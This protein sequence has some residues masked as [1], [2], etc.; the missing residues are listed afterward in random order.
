MA[1][2]VRQ[3]C[4]SLLAGHV[5]VGLMVSTVQNW[6]PCSFPA[7]WGSLC[8]SLIYQLALL[9]KYQDL[10]AGRLKRLNSPCIKLVLCVYLSMLVAS[11][12]F[13][14]RF[15]PV[16]TYCIYLM[17]RFEAGF[18]CHCPVRGGR[19][20]ASASSALMSHFWKHWL[21][22]LLTCEFLQRRKGQSWSWS[23]CCWSS[24]SADSWWLVSVVFPHGQALSNSCVG[25]SDLFSFFFP[26][27]YFFLGIL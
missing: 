13:P 20:R 24:L 23:S 19:E 25:E 1:V 4:V 26:F 9:G 17:F 11:H 6:T 21:V 22:D 12:R 27:F 15:H 8:L 3:A 14:I 2:H 10:V 5:V 7:F 18:E 16:S